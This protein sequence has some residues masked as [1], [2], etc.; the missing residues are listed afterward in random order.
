ML[1][2]VASLV[3]AISKFDTCIFQIR[4]NCWFSFVQGV[5]LDQIG[6]TVFVGRLLGI[7]VLGVWKPEVGLPHPFLLQLQIGAI[8]NNVVLSYLVFAH[9]P[10]LR[11]VTRHVIAQ[12]KGGRSSLSF[13]GFV[14]FPLVFVYGLYVAATLCCD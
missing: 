9:R 11:D 7:H 12:M 3:L 2:N 4:H 10:S 5:F 8:I 13:P 14:Q 6:N 1:S